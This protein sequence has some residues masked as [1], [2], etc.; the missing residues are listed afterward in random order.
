MIYNNIDLKMSIVTEAMDSEIRDF[1]KLVSSIHIVQESNMIVLQENVFATIWNKIK[2]LW[3]K[4]KEWLKKI[5]GLIKEKF[6]KEKKEKD[7][8]K[9]KKASKDIQETFK[10][11]KEKIDRGELKVSPESQEDNNNSSAADSDK[12]EQKVEEKKSITGEE[13]LERITRR[14]T[15]AINRDLDSIANSVKNIREKAEAGDEAMQKNAEFL[16]ELLKHLQ[17]SDNSRLQEAKGYHINLP[18]LITSD[19]HKE[20]VYLVYTIQFNDTEAVNILKGGFHSLLSLSNMSESMLSS[21]M[22][23]IKNIDKLSNCIH[24]G[25]FNITIAGEKRGTKSFHDTAYIQDIENKYIRMKN[26]QDI[27]IQKMNS[28]QE[29]LNIIEP[30]DPTSNND[31]ENLSDALRGLGD[32]FRAYIKSAKD[33]IELCK[34][35]LENLEELELYYKKNIRICRMFAYDLETDLKLNR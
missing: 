16:D 29:D 17:E 3:K 19:A 34:T 14:H 6:S 15:E 32:Y 2:D 35:T 23:D 20:F 28:M 25:L 1:N 18:D 7:I 8:K 13:E 9:V 5:V 11:A 22:R 21:A 4:F 26:D 10:E 30:K 24:N 12:E 33:Y 31:S 27:I